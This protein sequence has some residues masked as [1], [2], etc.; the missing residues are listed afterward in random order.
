MKQ[1]VSGILCTLCIRSAAHAVK[2]RKST[3]HRM[4]KLCEKLRH[5]YHIHP[6]LT[7][8]NMVARVKFALRFFDSWLVILPSRSKHQY[9]HIDEK[10]FY[11]TRTKCSVYIIKGR[12]FAIPQH[13]KHAIFQ[14]VMFLTAFARPRRDH[15]RLRHCNW[16]IGIWPLVEKDPAKRNS[17]NRPKGTLIKRPSNLSKDVYRESLIRKVLLVIRAIMPKYRSV[18]IHM[19]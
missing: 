2:I 18:I 12:K 3:F 6:I 14:K 19:Q 11:I 15:H 5:S 13:E 4:F 1:N 16:K 17:Q 9:L 7:M 8:K 10:W